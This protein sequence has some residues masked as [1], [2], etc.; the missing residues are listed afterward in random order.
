MLASVVPNVRAY[1]PA[2]AYE[3]AVLLREGIREMYEQDR[4]VFYYLTVENENYVQPAMPAG[5]EVREG[6]FKGMYRVRAGEAAGEPRA[7]LLGSGAIL[8]E[9]VRAQELLAADYGVAADVWSVTSYT[10]LQRDGLEAERW[11][12]LHP[13]QPAAGPLCDGLSGGRSRAWWSPRPII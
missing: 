1:D 2:Y 10:E 6:I 12:M 5:E 7:H 13:Q 9:V 8:N 4:D 11:N 3:I